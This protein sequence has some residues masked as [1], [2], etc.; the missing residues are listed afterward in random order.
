VFEFIVFALTGFVI[1]F[2]NTFF[3]GFTAGPASA[4][5]YFALIGGLLLFV[6][7]S[8]L[9]FFMPRVGSLLGLIASVV[10]LPWP[11]IVL[12]QEHDALGVA[13]TG[14][15]PLLAG[16]VAML[17]FIR[18]RGQPLLAVRTSPHWALRSLIAVLPLVVF[19]SFFNALL[20]L[21][22]IVRYPF[23]R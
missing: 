1:V 5:P 19:V 20:V 17:Q 22:V 12:L 6:V 23:S 21:Q 15:P 7:A 14:A 4:V 2:V 13:V 9:V 3:W 18:S 16:A 8:A 10:I 11:I